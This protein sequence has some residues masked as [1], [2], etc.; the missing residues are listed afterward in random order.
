MML[1]PGGAAAERELCVYVTVSG[2]V[3]QVTGR[4][5][6]PA[7]YRPAA[8]CFSERPGRSD[9]P[10]QSGSPPKSGS[11]SSNLALPAE[12]DLGSS[13]RRVTM[14][15]SI[16]RVN[17][18]WPRSLEKLFGRTPERAMAEAARAVSRALKSAAFPV[19]LQTLDGVW[20]VVFMGE[21]LPA[22]QI[23]A[24][25][26][27]NCHPGWMSPPANI[28]VVAERVASGCGGGRH[29]IADADAVLANVLIPEIGHAVE[30]RLLGA[31]FGQSRM[32]A[33]GFATWFQI[34][35]AEYAPLIP[36]GSTRAHYFEAARAAFRRNPGSFEF[37]GSGEDYARA[38]ML[39]V[40]IEAR[41]GVRGI[42]EVYETMIRERL[43][44]PAAVEARLGW[45]AGRL[46]SEVERVLS[47]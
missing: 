29:S 35:A 13:V 8:R 47:R 1:L 15:S 34:Y 30:Y 42:L 25:L 21:T 6:I 28:Y 19:S 5:Q 2:T 32:R 3:A 17:L 43:D 44:F 23:P 9:S 27:S 22:A 16:G 10:G 39:F 45:T 37:A 20:E 36:R 31:Y 18:R 26:I 11:R 46:Q 14:A 12:I 33:E 7:E 41:R 40:A 24:S 4:E 38:A